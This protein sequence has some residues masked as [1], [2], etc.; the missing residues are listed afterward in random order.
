MVKGYRLGLK[1]HM[2][3]YHFICGGKGGGVYERS[4]SVIMT[5]YMCR[6]VFV[7]IGREPPVLTV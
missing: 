7:I 1:V 5:I 6:Y 4:S 2:Q 3:E